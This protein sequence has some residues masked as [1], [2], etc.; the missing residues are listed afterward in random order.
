MVDRESRDLVHAQQRNFLTWLAIPVLPPSVVSSLSVVDIG[1]AA[2]TASASCC[3]LP[4][5][6]SGASSSPF[7]AFFFFFFVFA[8]G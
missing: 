4:S 7:S 6:A 1:S 5:S 2:L 8:F 3:S